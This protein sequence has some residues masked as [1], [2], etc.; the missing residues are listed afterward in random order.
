LTK[1]TPKSGLWI[2]DLEGINLR[3][4]ADVAD[5]GYLSGLQLLEDKIRFAT[6]LVLAEISGFTSPYFRI[7]SVI[8]ELSIGEYLTGFATPE[9]MEKGVKLTTK[10]SRM[11]RIKVNRIKIK[12]QEVNFDHA[13][14]ITDGIG[15]TLYP[16]TTDANGEAEIF[17]NYIS[18]SP[19]IYVTM[20]NT[21]INPAVTN[22][23]QGCSCYSKSSQYLLANGWNGS[24]VSTSSFGLQIQTNSE[25]SM[26]ELA[27]VIAQQLRFPILYKS[28]IEIVKEAK[29]SDRLNSV[30][31]LDDE[32]IDFLLTEFSEQYKL[33]FNNVVQSL[34]ELLKRIDDICVVCNQSRWI[35]GTP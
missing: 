6:E 7:N 25:C 27:C 34:P 17:P 23:K 28:G 19:E 8:D 11:I 16:F 33:H 20:D 26:N 24:G 32:K 2:N 35:Y 22:V 29:A 21:A 15:A 10:D 5:S 3:F 4:A 9:A 12:I 13:V 1:T 30:T 14:K 31:L 18:K